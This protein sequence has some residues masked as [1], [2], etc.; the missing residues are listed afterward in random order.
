[1]TA[2][3]FHPVVPTTFTFKC[4]A[5]ETTGTSSGRFAL[6]VP[7]AVAYLFETV[8]ESAPIRAVGVLLEG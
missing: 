3:V 6:F 4:A 7:A 5:T 1:M 2:D 8:F